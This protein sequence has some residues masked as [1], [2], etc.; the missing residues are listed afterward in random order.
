MIRVL[1]VFHEKKSVFLIEYVKIPKFLSN[2]LILYYLLDNLVGLYSWVIYHQIAGVPRCSLI[3]C[4]V[5][6]QFPLLERLNA[7]QA[8]CGAA[9]PDYLAGKVSTLKIC[10]V[11]SE[12]ARIRLSCFLRSNGMMGLIF[13]L[14]SLLPSFQWNDGLIF[15]LVSLLP[16]FQWNDGADISIGYSWHFYLVTAELE[17]NFAASLIIIIHN[18]VC[19]LFF[20]FQ[21]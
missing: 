13:P 14:V 6:E 8:K 4:V 11:R 2:W 5:K 17:F 1:I 3:R 19:I 21:L 7:A 20:H 18:I 10:S 15:P 16:S 9:P 12:V